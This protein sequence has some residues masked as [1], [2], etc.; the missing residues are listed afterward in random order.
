M[1][2]VPTLPDESAWSYIK[3]RF[4]N[5]C[6]NTFDTYSS[7]SF[8][9][10]KSDEEIRTLVNALQPNMTKVANMDNYFQRPPLIGYALRL[11]R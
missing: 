3:R 2:D 7:H 8:Q 6:L 10:Q 11:Y 5:T 1:G 9:H 4:K